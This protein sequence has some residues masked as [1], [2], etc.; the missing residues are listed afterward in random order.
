[1]ENPLENLLTVLVMVVIFA[2]FGWWGVLILI[3]L[4]LISED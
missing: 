2:S 4:W 3:A 1:M